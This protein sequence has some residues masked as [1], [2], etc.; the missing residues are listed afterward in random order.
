MLPN[1]AVA[2]VR[3]R[4]PTDAAPS[5]M[6]SAR[7]RRTACSGRGNRLPPACAASNGRRQST[8]S[9]TK[10]TTRTT[11]AVAK[12]NDAGSGRSRTPPIP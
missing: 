7:E 4:R 1:I 8:P 5:T 11:A 3:K 6:R 9:R 12:K 10:D 2:S